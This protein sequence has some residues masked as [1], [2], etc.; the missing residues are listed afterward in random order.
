MHMDAQRAPSVTV[1]GT[2]ALQIM[3][4]SSKA[5]DV[6]LLFGRQPPLLL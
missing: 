6:S 1:S 5:P 3:S 4:I 2:R